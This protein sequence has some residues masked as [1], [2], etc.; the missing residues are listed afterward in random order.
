[1]R[2]LAIFIALAIIVVVAKRMW[3]KPR[4]PASQDKLSGKMAQCAHCGMYIP[5]QEA[6]R[7]G[8]H[9]YCSREHLEQ[10]KRQDS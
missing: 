6:I 9:Y 4:P 7:Y 3:G 5:E 2:L 8:D 10:D 1:M